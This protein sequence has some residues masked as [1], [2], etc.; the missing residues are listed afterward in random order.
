MKKAFFIS[1]FH[2][3]IAG[4]ESSKE[5]E[6]LFLKW[7]NEYKPQM[8]ALYVVGDLFDFWFEYKMVVPK[9][10]V[11]ILAALAELQDSGIPVLFFSGNHDQWMFDYFENELGIPVYHDPI[12]KT[13]LGKN[14]I[15]GHG[16]GLG[17]GDHG[18]KFIKKIFRNPFSR[19]LF[20][21]IPPGIG[22]RL[23]HFWS[24]RSRIKG[25]K[26]NVFLGPDKEW[27]IQYCET[28]INKRKENKIDFFVFGHRHL[29]VQWKL[30]NGSYYINL[31]D[32]LRYHSFASFDGEKMECLF[33]GQSGYKF[34]GSDNEIKR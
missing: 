4:T 1:D 6:K 32:W 28:E 31:G 19:I 16:D 9:G 24:G 5:R 11:R 14:F 8:S 21:I 26:E 30:S 18:Y 20:S 22:M 10:G 13:I 29:P 27:L 7:I 12:E 34:I 23:A 2:F 25:V 15:I 33:Y 3:G 17:P